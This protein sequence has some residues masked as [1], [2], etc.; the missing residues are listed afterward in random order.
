MIERLVDAGRALEANRLEQAER[1]YRQVVDAD[2]RSSIAIV[3]LARVA[4]RRGDHAAAARLAQ[5]ALVIDPSNV[6]AQ[7]LLGGHN[8]VAA[9]DGSATSSDTVSLRAGGD[10]DWPWPD[11]EDQLARY[12]AAGPGLLARLLKRG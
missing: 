6:A 12:R 9:G 10:G 4:D 8:A 7:R 3:G 11:L 2:P 1:I 5:A